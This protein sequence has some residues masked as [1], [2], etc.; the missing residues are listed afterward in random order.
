MSNLILTPKEHK[1][2]LS[3][4]RKNVSFRGTEDT[5]KPNGH[6][7]ESL[8]GDGLYTSALSNKSMASKYGKLYYVVNAVPKNPLIMNTLNHWQIWMQ[9]LWKPYNFDVREFRKHTDIRTEMI[10]LGYD[11]V[12][13][14]GREMVNYTPP[15]TVRYYTTE[16][17]VMDYYI[18][19]RE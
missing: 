7:L 6:P 19:L 16:R 15:D 14:P 17:G 4:K 3:W 11:G 10:K 1:E 13:I 12:I 8:M 2:Y 9:R 5:T 18:N